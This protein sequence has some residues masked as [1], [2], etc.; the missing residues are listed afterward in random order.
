LTTVPILRTVIVE[1]FFRIGGDNMR[2]ITLHKGFTLVELLIVIALLGALAIGLIGALDPFEQLKKG[3][4]TGTRDLVNQ[5]QTAVLRYYATTSEMPW[6]TA[7]TFEAQILSGT[8]LAEGIGNMI[9]AG[10]MKS[11]FEDIYSTKYDEV[12]VT[13]IPGNEIG[14]T[15]QS[16]T[17]KVCYVPQS[18]SFQVEKNTKYTKAGIEVDDA[19][20]MSQGGTTPCA[21]CV[22]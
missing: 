17:V 19:S 4:D 8:D 6:T 22:Q 13:Y 18:K 5:V 12:F 11:N 16:V 20:C 10:E 15:A 2:K 3:T 9:K 1:V 21:W 7:A 14:M